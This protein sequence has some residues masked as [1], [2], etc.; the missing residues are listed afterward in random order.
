MYA[1]EL[2]A[3]TGRTHWKQKIVRW[4]L[5]YKISGPDV[6]LYS[7][8]NGTLLVQ[9]W[10]KASVNENSEPSIKNQTPSSDAEGELCVADLLLIF[11]ETVGDYQKVVGRLV[12]SAKTGSLS[13]LMH[14]SQ[15]CV[16]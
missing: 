10:I 5:L 14:R 4:D 9:G 7:N 13:H 3:G 15:F 12:F 2:P 8:L 6:K 11:G 16:G 1:E